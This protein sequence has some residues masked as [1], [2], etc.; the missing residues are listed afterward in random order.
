MRTRPS[1]STG[2]KANCGSIAGFATATSSPYTALIGSQ[3]YAPIERAVVR[4]IVIGAFATNIQ[5]VESSTRS[6]TH[7]SR[8]LAAAMRSRTSRKPQ[9]ASVSR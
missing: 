8:A 9:I 2:M 6:S 3:P 1:W 5:E 4:I 7:R